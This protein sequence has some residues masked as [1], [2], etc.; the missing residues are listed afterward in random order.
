MTTVTVMASPPNP[1][2]GMYHATVLVASPDLICPSRDQEQGF[3]DPDAFS[4]SLNLDDELAGLLLGTLAP[5]TP[6]QLHDWISSPS[7]GGAHE[8]SPNPSVQT[9]LARRITYVLRRGL[10]PCPGSCHAE[11]KRFFDSQ[12]AHQ[13]TLCDTYPARGAATTLADL[14]RKM[15]LRRGTDG[16]GQMADP[17][18]TGKPRE[19]FPPDARFKTLFTGCSPNTPDGNHVYLY[20]PQY[21]ADNVQTPY[22]D[23]D[24]ALSVF[25]DLGRLVARLDYMPKRQPT[26]HLS[27]SLHI[28]VP[29]KD[30]R[31]GMGANASDVVPIHRV[32]HILFGKVDGWPLYIFFPRMYG[33]AARKNVQHLT[34]DDYRTIYQDLTLPAVE[35]TGPDVSH[36]FP[37]NFDSI[38]GADVNKAYTIK[39]SDLGTF[40]GRIQET[41]SAV[42]STGSPLW[43]FGDPFFLY[44]R[45]GHKL[46]FK[47]GESVNKCL[48]LFWE[49]HDQWI[50]LFPSSTPDTL[51]QQYIDI[52]AEFLPPVHPT[53]PK[54]VI[55]PRRCCQE[56]TTKFLL[57]YHPS[58]IGLGPT[59]PPVDSDPQDPGDGGLD[60]DDGFQAGDD[61][62]GGAA[63]GAADGAPDGAPDGALQDSGALADEEQVA[64]EGRPGP[65]GVPRRPSHVRGA[66]VGVWNLFTLRD[67]AN[68]TCEPRGRSR[69]LGLQYFQSYSVTKEMFK[70]PS[71]VPFSQDKLANIVFGGD[72]W[73]TMARILKIQDKSRARLR[74]QLAKDIHQVCAVLFPP[75]PANHAPAGRPAAHDYGH[76]VEMRVTP[77]LAHEIQMAEASYCAA[78]M[79]GN[80]RAPTVQAAPQ[81][82]PFD[83]DL[84]TDPVAAVFD[85]DDP[86]QRELV[87]LAPDSGAFFSISYHEFGDFLRGNIDKHLLAMDSIT[88]Y[89][90][91][92]ETRGQTPI[93][94]A[95]VYQLLLLSLR[96]FISFLHPDNRWRLHNPV[97]HKSVREGKNFGG[98]GFSETLRKRGFGFWPDVVSWDRFM[99]RAGMSGQIARF[100]SGLGKLN[101]AITRF[102][103]DSQLLDEILPYYGQGEINR[104]QCLLLNEV[105]VHIL[106]VEYRRSVISKLYPGFS[107]CRAGKETWENDSLEFSAEGLRRFV[108]EFGGRE[109]SFVNGNRSRDTQNPEHLFRFLWV[110]EDNRKRKTK[111]EGVWALPFRRHCDRA[112][113]AIEASGNLHTS[114]SE[115]MGTLQVR[116]FEQHTAVPWMNAYNG[117]IVQVSKQGRRILCAWSLRR[118][119]LGGGFLETVQFL[120]TRDR[121]PDTIV[122]GEPQPAPRVIRSI[123]N[124]EGALQRVLEH[125]GS[126]LR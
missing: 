14:S 72:Q 76:R 115:L 107:Q 78:V 68:V 108:K 12:N 7:E 54:A 22:W 65:S 113:A 82:G 80:R 53:R 49:E 58:T 18:L 64:R 6:Q 24:S 42:E 126:G 116:F 19:A 77:L 74:E 111:G 62:G 31:A 25:T 41:L 46:Q 63:D 17:D 56:N 15:G 86:D 114:P 85:F 21:E 28:N 100:R 44:D 38:L 27:T 47:N 55:L 99:L 5:L 97:G 70:N 117:A 66:S 45:A 92:G 96:H 103:M 88:A 11:D 40:W 50:P 52:A 60:C 125:L 121:D 106:L 102:Q 32:P 79:S 94:V 26:R 95:T 69:E 84:P 37:K 67:T 23:V 89:W 101:F 34:D 20:H 4:D 110:N 1:K 98:L 71:S 120:D 16:A 35:A 109:V 73:D 93:D 118:P 104:D 57:D 122:S 48:N 8:G 75:R 9:S 83:E 90:L 36:H 13:G 123:R 29:V 124:K 10:V 3:E 43:R 87:K 59:P 105:V 51:D 2:Q 39:A 61:A 119:F 91:S 33:K 112:L 30:Y 81:A